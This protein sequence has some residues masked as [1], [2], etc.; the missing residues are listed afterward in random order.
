MPP[1]NS[2]MFIFRFITNGL[3]P[4]TLIGAILA[5]FIPEMF[6]IF[7]SVFKWMFA[8][9][10]FA[11][12]VVLEP[13]DLTD[14]LQHPKRIGL[15][16]LTQYLLMPTLAFIIISLVD[17]PPALAIGFLIVG[18]APGAMASNVIVYLAGG[19]MA[20]SIAMTTVATFLSPILTPSLVKILG[21]QIMHIDFWKMMQTILLTVVLPLSLG[22]V[23]RRQLKQGLETAKEIAPAV[24]ALAIIIICSYAVAANQARISQVGAEIFL[25][26]V[27]LNAL[28]YLGGWLLGKL[29]GFDHK[30]RL[31]LAIEI[32]MQNAGM[33]VVLAL[34]H[35][36]DTPEAALPGALFAVW[37][38]LTAAG[39]TAYFRYRDSKNQ[40]PPGLAS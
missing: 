34:A 29:Y 37:C 27:L 33:G 32:G 40:Q 8:A 24:A 25:L 1:Y 5:Y 31:T 2:P 15:G 7:G 14:T 6:L 20:F 28:G 4:L 38:I 30:H 18:A 13:D 17:L 19:A 16:V 3:A 12:G 11:L 39:A 10:M 35:F 21:G 23:L 26:V 9:T 22:M 36:K